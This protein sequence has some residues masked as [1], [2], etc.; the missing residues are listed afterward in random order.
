MI[1][2]EESTGC[3]VRSFI[4]LEPRPVL[5]LTTYNYKEGS[6]WQGP[7]DITQVELLPI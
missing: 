5:N 3:S 1:P 7:S 4:T 2:S 6:Q